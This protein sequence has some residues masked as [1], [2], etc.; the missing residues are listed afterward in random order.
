M[1]ASPGVATG[2]LENQRRREQPRSG[3]R[4]PGPGPLLPQQAPRPRIICS[5]AAPTSLSPPHPCSLFRWSGHA[6][7]SAGWGRPSRGLGEWAGLKFTL[8]LRGLEA[9]RPPA[10][11]SPASGCALGGSSPSVLPTGVGRGRA[12]PRGNW[13]AG[14]R[15]KRRDE[16]GPGQQR[17][18]G[19][20]GREEGVTV[21]FSRAVGVVR[22][23]EP[24]PQPPSPSPPRGLADRASHRLNT[25]PHIPAP[26]RGVLSGHRL[27]LQIP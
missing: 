27:G 2:L 19:W 15:G 3:G 22:L 4:R 18:L 17:A 14:R 8:S 21:A 1:R 24:T 13:Q 9:P 7:A 25:P 16:I 23:L 6:G 5:R 12:E 26:R 20:D 11:V 10:T